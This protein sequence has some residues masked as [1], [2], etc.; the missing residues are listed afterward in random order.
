[1]KKVKVKVTIQGTIAF[2]SRGSKKADQKIVKKIR[3][4]VSDALLHD[5]AYIPIY[6]KTPGG[7]VES[8]TRRTKFKI[9]SS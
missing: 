8:R 7:T 1:M 3:R 5:L 6:E 9:R 2:D 4:Y